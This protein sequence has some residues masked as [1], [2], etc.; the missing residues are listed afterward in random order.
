MPV[1]PKKVERVE[2][3]VTVPL[4]AWRMPVRF[5]SLKFEVKR[6]VLLAVVE[7]SEVEVA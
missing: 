6:L 2:E 4:I 1:P 7:K 3:E 5:A